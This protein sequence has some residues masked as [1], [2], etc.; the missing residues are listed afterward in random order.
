MVDHSV[1]CDYSLSL[2]DAFSQLFQLCYVSGYVV[3]MLNCLMS[4]ILSFLFLCLEGRVL[5]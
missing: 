1:L 4:N 3:G 5:F 2:W